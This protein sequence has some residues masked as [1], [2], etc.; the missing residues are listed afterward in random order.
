MI[1]FLFAFDV[2]LGIGEL[3]SVGSVGFS[4]ISLPLLSFYFF[5]SHS[6]YVYHFLSNT[7]LSLLTVRSGLILIPHRCLSFRPRL[8]SNVS[9]APQCSLCP[10]EEQNVFVPQFCDW[11]ERGTL[12]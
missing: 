7:L 4:R 12:P 2:L 10:Y 11:F 5:H 3:A 8:F 9:I 6:V 1:I